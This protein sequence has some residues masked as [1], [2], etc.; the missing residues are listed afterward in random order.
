M[1]NKTKPLVSIIIPTFNRAP[2][3]I[4]CIQNCLNQ[5]Y[6]NIEL[7]VVDDGSTDSTAQVVSE[8]QKKDPRVI[9]LK[10]INEGL[11]HALNF[12]LK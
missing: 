4:N 7:I 10:K 12:G 11:P 1:N 3:L 5:T 2:L 8:F 6:Q 9:Y